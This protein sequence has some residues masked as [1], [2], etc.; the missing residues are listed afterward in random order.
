[1]SQIR[2]PD[3]AR[4]E[5]DEST[6]RDQDRTQ[7]SATTNEMITISKIGL[8]SAVLT[9]ISSI[10]YGIAVIAFFVYSLSHLA[11]S[12][13]QEWTGIDAFLAAFQP[14]QMLPVIPSLFLAPTFTALMVSI[15]SY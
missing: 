3:V 2:I 4:F 1:M 11:S 6:F 12:Q 9:S 7:K 5:P 13:T 14:I 10:G 8:W 15:H